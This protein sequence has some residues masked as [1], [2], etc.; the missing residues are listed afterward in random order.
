MP[1]EL[2]E[3]LHEAIR[4]Y[5]FDPSSDFLKS[6]IGSIT[7]AR[8]NYAHP[9][10][11]WASQI[12]K[13][14]FDIYHSCIGTE[15]TNP[16]SPE[17]SMC[18]LVGKVVELVLIGYLYQKGVIRKPSAEQDRVEYI[19]KGCKFTGKLDADLIVEMCDGTPLEVKSVHNEGWNHQKKCGWT[20][21]DL[22]EGKVKQNFLAQLG[23]YMKVRE[24]S[25]GVLAIIN[26]GRGNH[27]IFDVHLQEN[28]WISCLNTSYNLDTRLSKLAKLMRC[29]IQ[30]GI[31]PKP[32]WPYHAPLTDELLD[33]FYMSRAKSAIKG[34]RIISGDPSC[35]DDEQMYFQPQYSQYKDLWLLREA[36]DRGVSPESLMEY[37][38]DEVV[39]LKDYCKRRGK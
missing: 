2:T 3:A 23:L 20:E 4:T 6:M 30:T 37:S 11:I 22:S 17:V 33:L 34:D 25:R 32:D 29:N 19:H 27:W 9:D 28:G 18:G 36:R 14:M 21:G 1:H 8:G 26:R 31:E 35:K 15:Q 38:P 13:P 24:K 12:T 5:R 16:V 7:E 39:F 10:R